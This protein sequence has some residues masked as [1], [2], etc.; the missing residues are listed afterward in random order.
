[1]TSASG[2]SWLGGRGRSTALSEPR[3]LAFEIDALML[4]AHAAY[5]LFS[6]VD[7]LERARRAVRDRLGQA[8]SGR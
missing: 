6:D 4:G 5:R 8:R 3:Q 2:S 1:M 7:D